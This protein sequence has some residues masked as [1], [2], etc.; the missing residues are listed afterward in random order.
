MLENEGLGKIAHQRS[1]LGSQNSTTSDEG[2][3]CESRPTKWSMG[4]LN[5]VRTHEVPGV[6][7]K[8]PLVVYV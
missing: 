2:L 7:T 5:D 4:V 6:T 8:M 1:R 3:E